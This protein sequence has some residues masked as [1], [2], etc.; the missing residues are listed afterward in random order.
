M[1][2]KLFIVI[3]SVVL[4]VIFN[5]SCNPTDYSAD[6]NSL[7]ASRD[8]LAAALKVTNFNL[9]TTNNNLAGLG[10]SFTAI[11]AQLA[12]ISGQ[13]T[14]LN[15][16]LVSTNATVTGNTA[17]I[18]SIQS[19]IKVIQDQIASL[20]AK[21]DSTAN[22]VGSLGL[23]VTSIQTQLTTVIGNVATLTS[24]QQATNTS[25][26]DITTK[27]TASM[28]QLSSLTTQF[29]KLLIQLVQSGALIKDADGNTYSTVTI[30]A[31]VWM[32]E[33]L[34]VS[35]FNDGSSIPLVTDNTEWTKLSTPGFCW[36][37]NDATTNKNTYGALY[38]WYTVSSGK[39]CPVGWHVPTEKELTALTTYLGESVAG[40]KLKEVGF[41]HWFNPNTGATNETGFTALP[42]GYRYYLNGTFQA[43]GADCY[44]WTSTEYSMTQAWNRGLCWYN[45]SASRGSYAYKQDGLSV[46]CLKD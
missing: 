23:T 24:Q 6:I 17:T 31:Q 13:I 39:L 14:I 28:N 18:T 25:L 27:L 8:S 44:C 40:G 46:R 37:N 11:Q 15:A 1:K 35:K 42:S 33:N 34:K 32:S 5:T 3:A 29:N 30:G 26:T 22:I 2:R 9:Q 19:Q 12:V 38:N 36:Y 10:N 7:K 45:T 43:K 16:Q 41:D 20:N 21:Q 4:V